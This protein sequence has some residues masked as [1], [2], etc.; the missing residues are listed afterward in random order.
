M[1]YINMRLECKGIVQGRHMLRNIDT[2][3]FDLDQTLLDKYQ[4]SVQFAAYQ[5]EQYSLDMF[6]PDRNEFILKFSE[7]NHLIMSKEEV[8]RKLAE[9]FKLDRN[10]Y[11]E[12]LADLNHK[13]HHYSVGYAGL[14]EMLSLLK[15]EGYKLGIVT[16]GRDF[17]QRNKISALG[18]HDYFTDIVTSGSVNIKKPDHA[19]FQIALK[20]LRS[21]GRRTVFV[22]DS[23]EADIIPAKEL[24]MFTILKAKDALST[25]PDA[26]CDD[27]IEI[28]N[29]IKSL[30]SN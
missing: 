14:H 18:I 19:I 13:F 16:N 6:I 7:L 17:Y 5:Y 20:H 27:L 23:I 9:L 1:W 15:R 26:I 22:G 8:Y 2:V 12:L 24:G 30:E 11:H 25:L 29:I 10:L 28:P 4:S 21:I 3:V